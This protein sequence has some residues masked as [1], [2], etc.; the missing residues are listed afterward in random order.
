MGL[1]GGGFF[2]EREVLVRGWLGER[3][4][5]FARDGEGARGLF[6]DEFGGGYLGGGVGGERED[7][8]GGRQVLVDGVG[9]VVG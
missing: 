7:G 4:E 6:E 5:L 1:G 2:E 8:V 9:G 3:L